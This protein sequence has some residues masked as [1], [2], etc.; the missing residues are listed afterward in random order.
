MKRSRLGL[1]TRK[2]FLHLTNPFGIDGRHPV[3]YTKSETGAPRLIGAIRKTE[4]NTRAVAQN[5]IQFRMALFL[6]FISSASDITPFFFSSI[7]NRDGLMRR[8]YFDYTVNW[9]VE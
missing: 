1:P 4:H 9:F 8:D 3:I 6:A 7:A 2:Q 5:Q